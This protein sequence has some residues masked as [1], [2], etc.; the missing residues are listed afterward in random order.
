ML[1]AIATT[2]LVGGDAAL[3]DD[4]A[5]D[6]NGGDVAPGDDAAGGVAD[7]VCCDQLDALMRLPLRR[8]GQ[9]KNLLCAEM[10]I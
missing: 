1:E 10:F 4:V 5:I 6:G 7:A 8:L 2:G 3:V 9:M